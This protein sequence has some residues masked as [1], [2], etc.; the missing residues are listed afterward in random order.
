MPNS[1]RIF[2]ANMKKIA[3]SDSED[4]EVL[5]GKFREKFREFCSEMND[6]LEYL[7]NS[8]PEKD[9]TAF[10]GT[11]LTLIDGSEP[12]E[13]DSIEDWVKIFKGLADQIQ[14]SWVDGSLD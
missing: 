4:R 10:F 12:G 6:A 9:S 3:E 5:G 13:E 2:Q 1:S 7:E 14:D 8:S 11:I